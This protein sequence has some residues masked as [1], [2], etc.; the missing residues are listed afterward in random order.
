VFS[1][2]NRLSKQHLFESNA[3]TVSLFCFWI[4]LA[5]ACVFTGRVVAM[6]KTNKPIEL[7]APRLDSDFSLEK[8]LNERRSTR[9]FTRGSITLA[10][11]SQMLW[12]AQGVTDARGYRTAPS[13]GALY[14]LE[15]YVMVGDVEGLSAGLYRYQPA[16]HTLFRI[17]SDDRRKQVQRAA[18]GQDWVGS[19]SVLFVFASEDSRTTGKYGERGIRYIHIE[20]GHAAQNLM[21]QS[22]ALGLG[23][24]VVGAF[25]DRVVGKILELPD[26]KRVLYLMPVGKPR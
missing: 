20:V 13:A 12:A 5:G 21:L 26:N 17:A 2:F 1:L 14:P 8:A 24:A 11:L 18:L 7:P 23:A 6:D 3:H 10:Q 25:E 4:L 15:V 19:N 16:G 9:E 22:Q